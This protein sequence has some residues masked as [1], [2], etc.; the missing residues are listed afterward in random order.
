MISTTLSRNK[1]IFQTV[2]LTNKTEEGIYDKYR[3]LSTFIK[4]DYCEKHSY[5]VRLPHVRESSITQQG[6]LS[7]LID[8]GD[9]SNQ[10]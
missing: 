5:P 6:I 2:R 1:T 3:H 10:K 4:V 8:S 9:K 7:N